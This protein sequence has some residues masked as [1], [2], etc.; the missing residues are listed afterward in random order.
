MA[1]TQ[2]DMYS[3]AKAQGLPDN[4]A[5]VAAAIGMAESGGNPNAHNTNANTGDNSYGLWQINM[6]GSLG[7][8]RLVQLGITSN[9][10]LF[11]PG[12]NAKAMRILSAN[13]TSFSPWSTYNHGD[14]QKYMS[15]T[16]TDQSKNQS[17]LS[18]ILHGAI[19]GVI[20]GGGAVTGAIGGVSNP[21]SGLSSIGDAT[22]KSAHWISDSKNWIRVIYVVGGGALVLG[23]L[24]AITSDTKLGSV[25]LSSTPPGRATS[26]VKTVKGGSGMTT[27]PGGAANV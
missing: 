2:T 10:Q 26:A 4:A 15:N 6:L 22:A 11:D 27:T 14:Y 3:L 9:D 13:G 19:N 23:A 12:T 25:I 1:L 5:K 8:A 20:P 7:P 17:W 18:T 16:V 24:I 21:L